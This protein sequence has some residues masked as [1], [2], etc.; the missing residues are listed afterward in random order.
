M[1]SFT[2]KFLQALLVFCGSYFSLSA[3]NVAPVL[4]ATGNQ[5]YCPGTPM[6]IVTDFNIVDPDDAATNAIYIQISSGYESGQD[7]LTL[8]GSSVYTTS[9]D[10]V[11]AKL[12]IKGIS[13]QPVPYAVLI[14]AV[15]SVKYNNTSTSPAGGTRTFSITVGQANYLPST[16][17]YY[18]Y[19][20][21]LGISWIAAKNAASTSTYYGLEGYLATLLSAEEAQLCGEQATGTGWIG[22]SD[23]QTE[24]V[25]RWV[26]GPPAELG[27]IFWNGGVNGSSPNFAFWNNGEPNNQGDEDYAHITAPGVGI[28]GS[29]NDLTLNGDPNGN[30]QPKG[31]IVEYGGMPGGPI[32]NIS[33]SSSI[34][35]PQITSATPNLI[36][37][38][39]S[40]LLQ[41]TAS[42]S[43]VYWYATASGGSPLQS[44][45][46]F[47]TPIISAT[48]TYYASA[49][50]STCSTT[51]PRTA[52]TATIKPLPTLTV[53]TPVT[54]CGAG[55]AT[56]AAVPSAGA[57]VNWYNALT[58]GTLIGTGNS[59]TSPPL[60]SDTTFYA[61]AAGTNGCT[62]ATREA[63][64][65]IV[66]QRPT[67]ILT[68]TTNICGPGIALLEATPSAGIVNWYDQVT[69]GSLIGTG[70]SITS[71][72]ITTSTTFYAEAVNNGCTAVIRVP[73]AVTVN[74]VPTVSGTTPATACYGQTATVS[75]T[76]S[77]GTI[78]WYFQATGGS[79]FF[80]GNTFTTSALTA[81]TTYYAEAFDTG[82]PSDT[83]TAVPV[84]VNQIPTVT[85]ITPVTT[86][87]GSTAALTATSAATVN[88]YTAATGGTLIGTGS[89][90]TSPPVTANTTFYAEAVNSTNCTSVTREPVNVTI[91]PLPTI[92]VTTPLSRC[93]EGTVVL[94]A[95]PS[96]GTVTWYTQASGGTPIATGNTITS[97]TVTANTSFY[98]EAVD[99]CTSATRSEVLVTVI[100]A[101]TVTITP[102]AAICD[103]GAI[104]LEAAASA[105]II[106]WYAQPTGG[107]AIAT[108][109]TFTTPVLT[110]DTTYYA[111]AADTACT[112]ARAAVTVVV[113]PLPTLAVT[114]PVVV[115]SGGGATLT[116]TP[117][118]GT[119]NWYAD[120]AGGTALATGM[121][122]TTPALTTDTVYYAEAVTNSCTSAA[123]EAV[124]ITVNSV[125][126][127]SNE[128]V[129]FC[130]GSEAELDAG[131][132][133]TYLWESE[134]ITQIIRVAAAG[135]YSVTITNT[136]GCSAVKT[137]TVYQR[138]RPMVK[139]VNL[140]IASIMVTLENK[141][142]QD[143]EFS[144]N[145][146]DYQASNYFNNLPS[147]PGTVYIREIHGCGNNYANYTI[148]IV[149]NFFTPNNDNINDVF[150]I[151]GITAYP[152]AVLTVFD[153][154]GKVITFLNRSNNAWDGTYNSIALPAD[155]YWYVL[156]LDESS[157]EIRGHFSLIR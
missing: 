110:A 121:S 137:F 75:A 87:S 156:R 23:S 73:L 62:S 37:G 105:G 123:R 117:S 154:Y 130:E 135:T 138:N 143:Y 113:T 95:I 153:R 27:T 66:K 71:P 18:Q 126:A 92:T 29:W 107:T 74:A 72:F 86:C 127:V 60:S 51:T 61:E 91:T 77:S 151:A 55:N 94:E 131:T 109:T 49:Y 155:D 26:T 4:T 104:T 42:G 152:N 44:G 46:S 16:G 101:P 32:L 133:G 15:K 40:V 63:V 64:N 70:N 24:G 30:Y 76:A 149:P 65:V 108:G 141:N 93:G 132:G 79:S 68:T 124:A 54:L 1:N 98:A 134:D 67:L 28:P 83:R 17:H 99:G 122:F 43:P 10:P 7:V 139:V 20:P 142:L 146:F 5:V 52:V 6:N 102:P 145:G 50:N 140:G 58:G 14:G 100:P 56:L 120:A 118:A 22:G 53:T 47:N 8:T 3:Q 13:G 96:S 147:G 81:D 119:V 9:W 114:T 36:C 150:K 48:T 78:R 90:I 136:S 39:G 31:Y 12:T 106:T 25:W 45:S 115:C 112:S 69:G 59:I 144:I 111:E 19:V 97:P 38:P 11:A 89:S 85:V 80:T 157:P 125:P 57:T 41:A 82:C 34:T 84:T 21:A 148:N 103:Q 128:V 35:I 129:Y 33:A 88:W 2:S 116:A